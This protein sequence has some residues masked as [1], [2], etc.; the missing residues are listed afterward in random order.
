[1][2]AAVGHNMFP[3]RIDDLIARCEA[4]GGLHITADGNTDEELS[5][6]EARLGYSLPT[7][8]R[9][10]LHRLGGGVYYMRHEIFGTVRVMTHDIELVPDVL[11]FTRW[12]GAT[13]PPGW[14]AVHRSAEGVH[15]IQLG[16]PDP[17]PVRALGGVGTTY[18]DFT[19]FLARLVPTR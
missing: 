4:D 9:A 7:A 14:L 8:Y 3:D 10:F 16:V 19:A 6:I 15:V 5:A 18:A 17:A 2:N 1:M 11:S 13:V 12:L